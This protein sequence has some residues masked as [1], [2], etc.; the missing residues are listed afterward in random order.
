MSKNQNSDQSKKIKIKALRD[1]APRSA[2]GKILKAGTIVHVTEEEAKEYCDKYF[3]GFPQGSGQGKW[4]KEKIYR[5]E[6][7]AG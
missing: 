6:R 7:V 2:G 1:I 4:P 3:T 5:A